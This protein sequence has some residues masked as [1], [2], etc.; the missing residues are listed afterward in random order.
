MTPDRIEQRVD[1]CRLWVAELYADPDFVACLRN[2]ASTPDA[3]ER[4]REACRIATSH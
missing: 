3:I 4:W 1:R 2:A